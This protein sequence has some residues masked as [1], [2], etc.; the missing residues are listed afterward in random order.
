MVTGPNGT[1]WGEK[2]AQPTWIFVF[3]RDWARARRRASI[4]RTPPVAVFAFVLQGWQGKREVYNVSKG[5]FTWLRIHWIKLRDPLL[6]TVRVG[7][8]WA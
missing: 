4:V 7:G 5:L 3:A 6:A 2:I 1:S 8:R